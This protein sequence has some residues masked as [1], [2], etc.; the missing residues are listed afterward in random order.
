MVLHLQSVE[1]FTICGEKDL[2]GSALQ[3]L[4]GQIPGSPVTRAHHVPCVIFITGD[5][6]LQGMRQVRGRGDKHCLFRPDGWADPG[7]GKEK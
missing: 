6:F 2:K 4:L 1:G 7:D 5:E 3:D